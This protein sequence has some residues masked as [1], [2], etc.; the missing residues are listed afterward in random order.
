MLHWNSAC[1]EAN[2]GPA[3]WTTWTFLLRSDNDTLAVANG[4]L[5]GKPD[6]AGRVDLGYTIQEEHQGQGHV[7]EAVRAFV[8]WAL[9][10]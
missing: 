1:P 3:G 4:G 2:P 5:K 9:E 7:A 6:S 8:E 10:P